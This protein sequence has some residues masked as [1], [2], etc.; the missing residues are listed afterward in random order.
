LPSRGRTRFLQAVIRDADRSQGTS[1]S[2][3]SDRRHGDRARRVL[4]QRLGIISDQIPID[5]VLAAGADHQE[6]G[7]PSAHHVMQ[8]PPHVPRL[9]AHHLRT[10]LVFVAQRGEAR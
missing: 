4:E 10:E 7:V 3:I 6:V 9:V 5:L 8:T 1:T 2:G